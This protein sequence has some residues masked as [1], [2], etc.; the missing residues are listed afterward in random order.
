MNSTKKHSRLPIILGILLAISF[1]AL[2]ITG[3][4]YYHSHF[5]PKSYFESVSLSN[6]TLDGAKSAV[7]SL[8]SDYSLTITDRDGVSY[9]INSDE[10]GLFV[11]SYEDILDNALI[12]QNDFLWFIHF[13]S[14]E[15]P[16]QA[17]FSYDEDKVSSVVGS[18]ACFDE[19]NITEPVDAYMDWSDESEE[20]VI[21]PEVM[22]TKIIKS[23]LISQVEQALVNLEASI[24][25]TDDEY[26]NP[27]IYSDDE[28][29]LEKQ[30]FWNKYLKADITYELGD[31]DEKVDAEKIEDW[32]S[33]SDDGEMTVDEDKVTSY[34]QYLASTY[35]T[36]GD[37]REFKTTLGD[38]ITIGGGDYGYVIDKEGEKEQLIEEIKSGT[39]VEREPLYEQEGLYRGDND[40]GDTY[41]EIDYTN[42]HIYYYE[43]GSLVMDSDVVTGNINKG[44]GSPDGVFKIVYKEKDATL[45]GEDYSSDVNF[46]MPF[47]YN[48]GVHDAPWRSSF[49]GQIY[50][51][52]GSHGC[53]NAPYDFAKKLF[54]TIAIGTPVVAYYRD[55]VV[56]KAENA[57]ISNA[58]SYKGND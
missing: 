27:S 29:L 5:F 13:F 45:V 47:A 24:S 52:S 18:L 56:L 57:R 41:L 1:V 30:S 51:S 4:I 12:T 17:S 50:K 34:V 10:C 2:Y 25:L 54:N 31:A 58:Y 8:V 22:G 20:Y 6:L 39:R 44:N 36:Y 37:E 7:D 28:E 3:F 11:P 42:Q 43:E 38:T 9:V 19:E 16:L 40:I 33:V 23:A 32:I 15:T 53:V 46:F 48:V 26:V 35:N 14:G 55:S 21:V 49:G